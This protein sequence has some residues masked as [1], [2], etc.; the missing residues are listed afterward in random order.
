ML[1]NFIDRTIKV[2]DIRNNEVRRHRKPSPRFLSVVENHYCLKYKRS[3]INNQI[4]KGEV[5]EC[6]QQNKKDA[7]L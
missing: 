1:R 4:V 5:F 2:K 6:N 7:L 3:W